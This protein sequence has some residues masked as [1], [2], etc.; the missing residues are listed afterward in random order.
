MK[1][2]FFCYGQNNSGGS[3]DYDEKAGITH[4]VVIEATS[5]KDANERAANIGLY[6]NGCADGRDCDCCGD[7]WCSQD[8]DTGGNESPSVYGTP[9]AE[10]DGMAWMMPGKE[11]AVHFADGRI[12]WHGTKGKQIA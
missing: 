4:H 12:E 5:S 7:R 6:F 10:F 11:I 3:F 2:K 1:T 8:E 9:I